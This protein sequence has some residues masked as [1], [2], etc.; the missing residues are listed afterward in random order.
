VLKSGGAPTD[1][2]EFSIQPL[3]VR[4]GNRV[5]LFDTGAGTNF[6]PIAGALPQSMQAAG[7]DPASVTDIFISH[8]HGDH[9]GGLLTP[10]MPTHRPAPP[11]AWRSSRASQPVDSA[12]MPCISRSPAWARS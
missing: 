8:V 6:G 2:F 11:A 12:C 5:L 4:A 9:I 3:L 1:H 7:V 10:A